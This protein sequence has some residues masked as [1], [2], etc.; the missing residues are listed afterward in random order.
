MD[1]ETKTTGAFPRKVAKRCE[2]HKGEVNS[3]AWNNKG[4]LVASGSSDKMVKLWDPIQAQCVAT[5]P[6][7]SQAVMSVA[8]SPSG[9]VSSSIHDIESS[10]VNLCVIYAFCTFSSPFFLLHFRI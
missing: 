2:G 8:F 1:R 4:T 9:L 7:A 10:I 3:I 6:G 5:L